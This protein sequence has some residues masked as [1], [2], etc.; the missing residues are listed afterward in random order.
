MTILLSAF[1][2]SFFGFFNLL[3]INHKFAYFQLFYYLLGILLFLFVKKINKKFFFENS[4]FFYWLFI[5]LLIITYLVGY[6]VKG[7]VRWLDFYFFKFQPSEFLKIFFIIFFASFFAKKEK[8]VN[9]RRDFFQSLI[10]FFLPFFLIFKQPDLGNAL[11]FLYIFLVMFIF[12]PLPKKYLFQMGLVGLFIIPFF[13]LLLKPYQKERVLAYLFPHE[14]Q[15]TTSYHMIQS[16]ITVGSGK[17]FGRGLGYGTQS[18]LFFLPENTTDFAYAALVEQFGF[19]LGFLLI[20]LYF[21]IIFKGLEFCLKK[22][23]SGNEL[24]K[25]IYYYRIGFSS[26]L[27]FHVVV[28]IGMTLGLLPITGITLPLIS[29]GGSSILTFA[30]GLSLLF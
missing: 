17:F 12:S 22:S 10:Y 11:V 9:H 5:F 19:S 28:N 7:A 15:Q 3:G 1:L 14:N 27:F 24:E 18:K 25:E 8:S 16:I 30:F 26:Y 4:S 21:L 29:Y 6:Q 2:I 20:F 13:W 23:Q